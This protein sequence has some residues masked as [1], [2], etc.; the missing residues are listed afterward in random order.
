[1]K[2]KIGEFSK[3]MVVDMSSEITKIDERGTY[4]VQSET[5]VERHYIVKFMDGTPVYCSCLDFTNRSMRDPIHVCKHMKGIKFYNFL[6]TFA[7][8]RYNFSKLVF[9]L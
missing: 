6:K 9:E 7:V 1:M 4:K 3:E 8:K 5:N 2:K